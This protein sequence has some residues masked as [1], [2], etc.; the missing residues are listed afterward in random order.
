MTDNRGK[1]ALTPHRIYT[2]SVCGAL[3]RKIDVQ[4]LFDNGIVAS[5]PSVPREWEDRFPV[6][7]LQISYKKT[8]TET[9]RQASSNIK[10]KG[11]SHYVKKKP[12]RLFLNCIQVILK[13]PKLG[14]ITKVKLFSGKFQFQY[15]L[16]EDEANYVAQY[17]TEIY[18]SGILGVDCGYENIRITLRNSNFR[19]YDVVNPRSRII[20]LREKLYRTLVEQGIMVAFDTEVRAAVKVTYRMMEDKKDIGMD[21]AYL[22]IYSSGKCICGSD[23]EEKIN[24]AVRWFSDLLHEYGEEFIDVV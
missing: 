24:K 15:I 6:I 1:F 13:F 17:L 12:Q 21:H 22:N 4:A 2:C 7:G 9:K 23:T 10:T 16:N 18:I 11:V 5:D 3:T 14:R 8:E 19:I 20:I